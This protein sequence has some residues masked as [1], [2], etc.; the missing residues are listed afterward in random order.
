MAPL[1][2]ERSAPEP[3][4]PDP[5]C[6][7]CS[8]PV[9]PGTASQYA[10]RPVHMRCLAEQTRLEAINTRDEARR[11]RE[12]LQ[13]SITPQGPPRDRQRQ[14][15]VCGQS[16]SN[17][18]SVLFQDDQLVHALCWRADPPRSDA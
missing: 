2:R 18:G 9:R 4:P 8:K 13:R 1:R 15:P 16:L 17:L 14:C 11:T 6:T 10:G 7:R 3:E 5:V 12:A